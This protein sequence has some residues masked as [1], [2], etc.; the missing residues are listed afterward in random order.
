MGITAQYVRVTDVELRDILANGANKVDAILDSRLMVRV[1]V[2]E[3][4]NQVDSLCQ[5]YAESGHWHYIEAK[6]AECGLSEEELIAASKKRG[7]HLWFDLDKLYN[8]LHVLLTGK[9]FPLNLA[10][11]DNLLSLA[12]LA[13]D[14]IRGTDHYGYGPARY[15]KPARVKEIADAL[16]KASY[17]NL[18]EKHKFDPDEFGFEHDDMQPEFESFKNFYLRAA[19]AGDGIVLIFL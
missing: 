8:E 3:K 2:A 16:A 11:T 1:G 18:V 19:Q 15:I 13:E 17:Q 14:N 7:F 10:K 4:G 9:K 5:T 12:V 6:A